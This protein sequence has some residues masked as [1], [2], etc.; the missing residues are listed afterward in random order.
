[1]D[2][3]HLIESMRD[4]AYKQ[5]Y[6]VKFKNLCLKQADVLYEDYLSRVRSEYDNRKKKMVHNK[7]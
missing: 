1:M 4:E 7:S 3:G 2:N 5:Y 6:K